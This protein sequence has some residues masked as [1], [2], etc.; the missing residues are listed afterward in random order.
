MAKS[1]ITG[2]EEI[3][4]AFKELG[5]KLAR[6][7]IRQAERKALKL[8]YGVAREAWPVHTGQS[9]KTIRIRTSKGPRGARNTT[10]AMALLVGEAGKKGDKE[11]GIKRAFWAFMIEHGFHTGAKRIRRGGK[12]V[13]Y[14]VK[15]GQSL[16]YHPGKFIMKHALKSTEATVKQIMTDE[17][18]RGI[19]EVANK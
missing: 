16:V 1:T 14:K 12:T 15:K 4:R 11:Q 5:P 2:L 8:P 10:I 3:K 19:E 13:G 7:V 18:I 9:R 6:R 17:I